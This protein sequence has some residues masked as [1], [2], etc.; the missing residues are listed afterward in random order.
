MISKYLFKYF[1]ASESSAPKTFIIF[2]LFQKNYK[3]KNES[4]DFRDNHNDF[5]VLE[6]EYNLGLID[7]KQF[8]EE[9]NK[10]KNNNAY[11]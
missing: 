11:N 3:S 7:K 8:E 10:L 4:N 2:P 1:K 9:K 6:N 5:E